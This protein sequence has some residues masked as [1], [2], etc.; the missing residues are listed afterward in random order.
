MIHGIT[1]TSIITCSLKYMV[2]QNVYV[3]SKLSRLSAC[4]NLKTD[5]KANQWL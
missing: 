1:H 2:Q 3:F 4:S 5:G